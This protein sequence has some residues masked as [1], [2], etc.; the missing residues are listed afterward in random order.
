[1]YCCEDKC[2]R[3][4]RDHVDGMACMKC[5]CFSYC[6][7]DCQTFIKTQNL[8]KPEREDLILF[9]TDHLHTC[10]PNKCFKFDL[11]EILSYNC[12]EGKCQENH[13]TF[14]DC[15][16][17]KCK[18]RSSWKHFEEKKSFINSF[19]FKKNQ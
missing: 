19:T 1:M 17:S 11:S 9:S 12:R 3:T 6:K 13:K 2:F 10:C 7:C 4:P 8:R 14:C 15:K 16:L 18:N 5:E